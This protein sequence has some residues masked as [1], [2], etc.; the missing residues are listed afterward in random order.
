MQSQRKL[1]RKQQKFF[2]APYE[3]SGK[4]EEKEI[5]ATRINLSRKDKSV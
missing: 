4:T 3:K 1:R 2:D 5:E